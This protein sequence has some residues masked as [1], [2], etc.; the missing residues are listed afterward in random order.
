M[1]RPMCRFLTLQK[2]LG[3]VVLFQLALSLSLPLSA[4]FAAGTTEAV[5]LQPRTI[6]D[7]DTRQA[8]IEKRLLDAFN[9]G[10]LTRSRME[11]FKQ[12]LARVA[13]QEAV[14]KAG[15]GTLSLWETMRLQFDL[16]RIV[17][18][19]E[20]SL[21]DRQSGFVDPTV[22][23]DEIA[24]RLARAF[25]EGRLTQQ[26]NDQIQMELD[27]FSKD[28]K[29]ATGKNGQIGVSDAV[30][31]VLGLDRLSQKL[32]RTA[33]ER[34]L[35]LSAFEARLSEIDTRIKAGMT[36]GQLTELEARDIKDDFKQ[37]S[38]KESALKKAKRPL[39]AAEQLELALAI[40]NLNSAVDREMSDNDRAPVN[41]GN[42]NA[43][44]SEIDKAIADALSGGLITIGDAQGYKNELNAI[45]KKESDFK[46]ASGT[47]ITVS[48]AQN[49]L[50]DIERLSGKID[51]VYANKQ[52]V[53]AGID[54]SI[55]DIQA[56]L[57]DAVKNSRLAPQDEIEIKAE[58]DRILAERTNTVATKRALDAD[59]AM[60][61]A[62][63]LDKLK[64]KL[65]VSTKD[66]E[67]AIIPD[68]NKRRNEVNKRIG[69][70]VVSGKL[71]ISEGQ[72]LMDSLGRV[73]A[74]EAAFRATD[75]TI[76]EREK[77]TLA[78]DLERV[79]TDTEKQIRDNPYASKSIAERKDQV[80]QMI[81]TGTLDGRLKARE[82]QD[83][84]DELSRIAAS[85]QAAIASDGYISGPEAIQLASDLDKLII[86]TQAH[87]K[88]SDTA[89]PDLAKREAELYQRITEGV[90]QGR[91]PTSKADALK[92]DFYRIMDNEAKY[93]S[94]GGLSFGEHA[95]LA[96][97]LER[98]ANS[99]ES[100]MSES[101]ATLP[102]V[103]ARQSEVDSRVADAVASGKLSPDMAREFSNELDRISRDEVNYRFSGSGLSYAE[104]LA[105]MTD[106]ETVS[107]K[108]DTA[109]AGATGKW[110]SIGG[111]ID[112][113]SRRITQSVTDKKFTD[114]TAAGLRRELDRVTQARAAFEASGGALNLAETQSLV[115]DLDRLSADIDGHAG[116]GRVIAW[117]D[118][119]ARQSRI[120]ARIASEAAAG[121]LSADKVDKAKKEL[122]SFNSTKASMK[123]KGNLSYSQL[124]TLAQSLDKVIKIAGWTPRMLMQNQPGAPASQGTQSQ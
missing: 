16:D 36:S 60:K 20:G 58:L 101:Q 81:S 98:L 46:A 27:K 65:S 48:E 40:E 105:L 86:G 119:D 52:T 96:L 89:L 1:H 33:H 9:C 63:D 93:R 73:A 57:A 102:D 76:D 10:R 91:L 74:K 51:R 42:V 118:I 28:I 71:T 23:H 59:A 38:D 124:V 79:A 64:S 77:L 31:L 117:T 116:A 68:L 70:G 37:L 104:S 56:K 110:S 12:E 24:K 44:K 22:R 4:A 100:N 75:G 18:E 72:D 123:N 41:A 82:V 6:S 85:E 2:M 47:D 30:R 87:L 113:I 88:D 43:R 25:G 114:D 3:K 54:G 69:E 35:S 106:L 5:Q 67:I 99:I 115:R 50:I 17:K 19:I 120:E 108:L 13:D 7:V 107:G 94:S 103:D 55:T 109:I 121:R 92:K 61:I 8:S 45:S 34:Q 122:K 95:A 78:L 97:E 53:W 26:E 11:G 90:M 80:D 29:A 39:T 84:R 111:R 32:T 21:T 49:L 62:G 15:D 14:F 66:R 83:L 112:E